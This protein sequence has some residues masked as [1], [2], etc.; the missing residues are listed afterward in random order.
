MFQQPRMWQRTRGK[1]FMKQRRT[2][3]KISWRRYRHKLKWYWHLRCHPLLWRWY[4]ST[5]SNE[6][7]KMITEDLVCTHFLSNKK[8]HITSSGSAKK[9]NYNGLISQI[10]TGVQNASRNESG[11]EGGVIHFPTNG[12]RTKVSDE[13]RS[14]SYAI[15]NEPE[16]S[17]VVTYNQLWNCV[18]GYWLS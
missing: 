16:E 8:I 17:I 10:I 13:H 12:R 3:N 7:I 11:L 4:W 14:R 6:T 2:R 18:P 5:L 9:Y 1:K 15:R